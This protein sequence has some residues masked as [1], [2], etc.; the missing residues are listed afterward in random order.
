MPK[1]DLPQAKP[2]EVPG[3]LVGEPGKDSVV[4]QRTY[5]NTRTLWIE[6]V[7]GAIIKGQEHQLATFAYNGEDKVTATKVPIHYDD[8]TVRR[9]SKVARA[10]S[11]RRVATSR[12]PP[13]C[14]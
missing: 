11:P 10:R 8:D 14:T 5:Q 13:S 9:T 1:Q 4:V 3:S 12:R 7:T 6:P 2:L